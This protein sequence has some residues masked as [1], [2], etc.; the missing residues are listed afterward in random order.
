MNIWLTTD[1]HFGHDK[2]LEYCGRPKDH[3]ERILKALYRI[4]TEDLIIHLGDVCIEKDE[5]WHNCLRNLSNKILI[6]GN[7][8]RKSYNW[9]LEHGWK[10]VAEQF[11]W[12]Y[13][14]KR[15][16]FSHIPL[17]NDGQFDINI[18]GHFHN[19]LKRMREQKWVTPDEEARNKGVIDILTPKHKLLALEFTNYQPVLLKTFLGF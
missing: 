6:I 8:D 12:N 7:H 9:Y 13:L 1:T 17:K 14:G 18:H 10:F 19:T 4:P 5:Y 11:I 15:I 3:S 2:M 16:L